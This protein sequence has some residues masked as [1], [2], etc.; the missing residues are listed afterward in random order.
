MAGRLPALRSGAP[1]S[2]GKRHGAQSSQG[3]TELG[4]PR[5]A[6][7]QV[8][9]EAAGRAGEP[10]GE[11]RRSAAGKLGVHDFDLR[12]RAQRISRLG[13]GVERAAQLGADV[14]RHYLVALVR[15]PS[16]DLLEIGDGG[17]G[18]GG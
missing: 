10:S 17:L 7:R 6:R 3:A 2:R 16:V 18:G 13:S 14:N 15:R 9:C 11:R 8:Q 12:R 5:P 4:L 1:R